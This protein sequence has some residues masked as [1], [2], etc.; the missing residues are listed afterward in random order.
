MTEQSGNDVAQSGRTPEPRI[1][2]V[3]VGGAGGNGVDNMISAGLEGVEFLVVNTDGQALDHSL[4]ENQIQIGLNLTKGLGAGSRPEI[5]KAAAEETH[6]VILNALIGSDMAFIT[7]GM[8][9]GTGTGA[10][11]VIAQI[12]REQG[13]LT[14]GVVTRPFAFE[15]AHRMLQAEAGIAELAQFVDTLIVIPNQNLFKVADERTTFAGAF[16]LADEV[17]HSGVRGVS[18]LVVLPGLVNLD[19]ADVRT[20]MTDMG[21]AVMGT[22]EAEGNNRAL[23]AAEA[24]I[25]NP[26]IGD[27]SMKGARSVL[28]NITGGLDLMLVEVDEAANRIREEVD[29]DANIIFG[30]AFNINL[31]GKIRVSV[32]A[33]GN[34]I[35]FGHRSIPMS[36]RPSVGE[37]AESPDMVSTALRRES[38]AIERVASPEESDPTSEELVLT[39]EEPTLASSKPALSTESTIDVEATGESLDLQVQSSQAPSL[40]ELLALRLV[41]TLPV[42]D[43]EQSSLQHALNGE[44]SETMSQVENLTDS[45]AEQLAINHSGELEEKPSTPSQEAEIGDGVPRF[46]RIPSE[47]MARSSSAG[48]AADQE[49]SELGRPFRTMLRREANRLRKP[50]FRRPAKPVKSESTLE[51]FE[52]ALKTFNENRKQKA[53]VRVGSEKVHYLIWEIG[54]GARIYKVKE[55]NLDLIKK[56]PG[57]DKLKLVDD[58]EKAKA[59]A[60]AIFKRVANDRAAKGLPS[61]P[62]IPSLQDLMS[63]EEKNVPDYFL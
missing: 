61:F 14:V 27:V 46:L 56:P 1:K 52:G 13:V 3:G 55:E 16:K 47:P 51:A 21:K 33:T 32:I 40:E 31:E 30:S 39:P 22:G 24:A 12:A 63:W 58:L 26:L 48:E 25:S 6:D 42:S 45:T 38:D 28:V 17:L 29:P 9:G 5:G 49:K 18:D 35:E 20:I 36:S 11:P 15:G 10:A 19:F 43:Y 62:S 2:V 41:T 4:C 54:S 44:A 60:T 50:N 59:E 23:A 8:G 7:A 53:P 57:A 34:D 37:L